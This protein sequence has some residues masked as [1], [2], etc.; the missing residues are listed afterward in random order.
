MQKSAYRL[1]ID[2]N[3]VKNT[4]R[5]D[6]QYVTKLIHAKRRSCSVRLEVAVID[7]ET[8]E[9]SLVSSTGTYKTI[10]TLRPVLYHLNGSNPLNAPAPVQHKQCHMAPYC[11]RKMKISN[12]PDHD[13]DS[14]INEIRG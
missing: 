4:R 1:F 9:T 3:E 5:Y 8:K 10:G 2:G 6:M 11:G 7:E 13:S 14:I 12:V